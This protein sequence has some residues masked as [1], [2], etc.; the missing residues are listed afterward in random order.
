MTPTTPPASPAIDPSLIPPPAHLLIPTPE[1]AERWAGKYV[2]WNWEGTAIL[3]GADTRE[4]L[5]EL[6]DRAER[7]RPYR[8]V[9]TWY[10]WR[11]A[12]PVPQSGQG[13]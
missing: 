11:N 3:A 6:L 12:G 7:W 1:E 9:A 4:E 8:S 13:G 2:A 10:F 5:Y